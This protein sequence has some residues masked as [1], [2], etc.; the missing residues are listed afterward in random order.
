MHR[1]LTRVALSA[2]FLAGLSACADKPVAV[3][4]TPAPVAKAAVRAPAPAATVAATQASQQQ[5]AAAVAN[6]IA[7]ASVSIE[8]ELKRAQGLRAQGNYAEATKVLGQLV[9]VSPDDAR[10]VGEYGKV[11]VQQGGRSDDAI[12]FLKRAVSLDAKD[13]SLYSA[14][15]VAYDQADDA[16]AAKAA[17]DRAL[18][19]H[20][21]DAAVLNNYAVSRMLAG[22]YDGA[23]KLLAQAQAAGASNPKVASNLQ[24]LAQMRA[25]KSTAAAPAS[26]TS[27]SVAAAPQ[28]STQTV[29][30]TPARS[31]VPAGPKNLLPGGTSHPTTVVM[32]QVPADS[33]AGPAQRANALARKVAAAASAK[34]KPTKKTTL[35]KSEAPALRTAD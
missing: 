33:H 10:I 9:L 19:L 35:A 27:K 6:A 23:Q 16:K 24:L 20:P 13:A 22:D 2:A 3:G 30:T 29:S 21:G 34:A 5:N 7:A 1:M 14:L 32:Q 4:G 25:S 31:T 8:A 12:A 11:L 28:K 15:G 18:A 26:V 17:Y